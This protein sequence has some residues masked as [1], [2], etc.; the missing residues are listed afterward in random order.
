MKRF[1]KL[2]GVVVLF[3]SS[4]GCEGKRDGQKKESAADAFPTRKVE[5]TVNVARPEI[6]L[7]IRQP[8]NRSRA[9]QVRLDIDRLRAF[10]LSKEDVINALTPSRII[11]PKEP[12]PPPGV[13][14][15]THLSTPDLYKNVILKADAEGNI[16][17]L[18][19]VAKVELLSG[20][21]AQE[22]EPNAA[23]DDGGK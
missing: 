19:D 2:L 15:D 13:V 5:G 7:H 22:A 6:T 23:P 4:I 18:K 9:V 12:L 3:T 21:K 20:R 8:G 11:D 10:N 17:R 14:F 1:A 16:V